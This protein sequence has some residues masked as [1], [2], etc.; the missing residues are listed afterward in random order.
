MLD[1]IAELLQF[2]PCEITLYVDSL[3]DDVADPGVLVETCFNCIKTTLCERVATEID[4]VYTL[5]VRQLHEKFYSAA[6]TDL[7]V[8]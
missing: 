6:I 8:S 4:S 2:A 1:D 3:E 7:T 5:G